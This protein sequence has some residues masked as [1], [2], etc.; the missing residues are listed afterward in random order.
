MIMY[1]VEGAFSFLHIL[2]IAAVCYTIVFMMIWL[3]GKRKPSVK[4]IPSYTME[5]VLICYTCTILNITGLLNTN[6]GLFP[7]FMLPNWQETIHF[8]FESASFQM[9]LLNF[10]M[11]VPLGF[12]LPLVLHFKKQRISIAIIIAVAFSAFIEILQI[13]IGRFFEIDDIISNTLGAVVGAF[14]WQSTYWIKAKRYRKGIIG[15][16]STIVVAGV[17]LFG[18]SFI[19]NG[20]R[21]QDDISKMYSELPNDMELEDNL[22]YIEISFGFDSNTK[23]KR[24]TLFDDM[25]F[26]NVY[27][28]METDISNDISQYEISSTKEIIEKSNDIIISVYLN[29]PQTFTF[30]NNPDIVMSNVVSFSYD[31]I[32]GTLWYINDAES[33]FKMSFI[34]NNYAF[35]K[36]DDLI[37]ETTEIIQILQQGNNIPELINLE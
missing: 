2:P 27:S 33:V 37:A 11:F 3:I 36:N 12:L 25:R 15:I 8:P 18:I 13:F 32:D 22:N 14:L 1:L 29:E 28:Q 24:K 4:L 19:A 6:D 7:H 20:D 23:I 30:Y 35:I 31:V 9:V 26:A 34:G 5:F 16:C 21:L 10:L 17:I